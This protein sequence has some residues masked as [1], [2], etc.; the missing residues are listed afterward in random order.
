MMTFEEQKKVGKANV[1]DIHDK[2]GYDLCRI[3]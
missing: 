1:V 2:Y 3:D